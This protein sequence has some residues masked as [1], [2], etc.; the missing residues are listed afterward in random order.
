M[1]K[2]NSKSSAYLW[3]TVSSMLNAGAS[4]ILLLVVNRACG[5]IVAGD[6]TL[7]FSIAQLMVTIGYFELRSYQVTDVTDRHTQSEYFTFKVLSCVAMLFISVI[8]VFING[9]SF[10]RMEL[11]LALCVFKM[12]DAYEEFF[13][14]VLQRYNRLGTGAK[15]SSIRQFISLVVFAVL[16]ILFKDVVFA[17]GVCV[18][19]SVFIIYFGLQRNVN[20]QYH[21]S[22]HFDFAA[23]KEILFE[24]LPLF[25]GSY[26]ILYVGNAPKYA[27]DQ[28]MSESYQTYYAILFMPSFVINLLSGFV[29]KPLLTDMSTYYYTDKEKY[30]HIIQKIG[31]AL[32]GIFVFVLLAAL[33]LGIPVLNWLYDVQLDA[34]Q[35]EFILMII[36]GA[37]SALGVIISYMITI[38]RCQKWLMVSYIV[39]AAAAY[40]LS[41][42]LVSKAGIRGASI[43]FLLFSAIRTIFYLLTLWIC[44]RNQARTESSSL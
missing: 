9:Y 15:I 1:E 37:L 21:I 31:I 25:I 36:G 12:L 23:I 32:T 30:K 40:L 26:L 11:I 35:F 19:V 7:A 29:F 27:I 6:F 18:A 17:V 41:P 10:V 28:Y 4:A 39:T 20:R 13:V 22:L 24:C 3:N 43:G 16:V 34:Y 5:T 38:M 14:T 44:Q 2:S 42:L 8:Y 33:W